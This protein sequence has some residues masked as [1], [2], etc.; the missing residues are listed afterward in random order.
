MGFD[1]MQLP[2]DAEERQRMMSGHIAWQKV[3]AGL[4]PLIYWERKL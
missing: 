3:K 4:I 2:E 1:D